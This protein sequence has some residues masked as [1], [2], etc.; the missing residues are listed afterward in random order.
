M[1]DTD[2]WRTITLGVTAS[3]QTVFVSL[4][5]TF[6]WWRNFLGRALFGKAVMLALFINFAF[7]ARVFGFGDHDVPFI[8][9]YLLLAAG[10]ILE[11]VAFIK[12]MLSGKRKDWAQETE[13]EHGI[14]EG[15]G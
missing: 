12:V 15:R 7:A 3:A 5:L 1:W 13:V 14:R 9:L 10:V 2:T 8:I 4:Y 11:V 6:P